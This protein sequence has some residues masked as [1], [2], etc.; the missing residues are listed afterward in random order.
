MAR[1]DETRRPAAAA[2]A[3]RTG[4]HGYAPLVRSRGQGIP[5]LTPPSHSCLP[6]SPRSQETPW[7]KQRGPVFSHFDGDRR[8]P[9]YNGDTCEYHTPCIAHLVGSARANTEG[10]GEEKGAPLMQLVPLTPSSFGV[11]V[12]PETGPSDLARSRKML[13]LVGYLD[14]ISGYS[15]FDYRCLLDFGSVYN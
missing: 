4:E 15:I 1:R 5:L 8:L 3:A 12:G 11:F 9:V 13:P 6:P 10:G 7:K 14:G 2:S